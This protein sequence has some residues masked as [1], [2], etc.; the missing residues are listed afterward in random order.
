MGEQRKDEDTEWGNRHQ[1]VE[2]Y[3]GSSFIET[4][5]TG[6]GYKEKTY[7]IEG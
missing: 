6:L 2:G 3:R 4:D 1:E 5:L 7:I